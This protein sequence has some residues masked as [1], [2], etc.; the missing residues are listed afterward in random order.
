MYEYTNTN[1]GVN[2]K[3]LLYPELSYKIIG[4]LFEIYNEFGPGYR[5]KHYENTVEVLLKEAGL[6][7]KKTTYGSVV[8]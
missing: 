2:K 7:Y 3:D 5:E 6:K 4:I 8:F 1:T